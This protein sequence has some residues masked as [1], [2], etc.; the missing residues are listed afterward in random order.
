[1]K[2]IDDIVNTLSPEERELHAELIGECRDRETEVV[3]ISISSQKNIVRIVDL[4][5]K[6][7]LV[8]TAIHDAA[9]KLEDELQKLK[10]NQFAEMLHGIPDDEFHVA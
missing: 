9:S 1:M 8:L 5:S 7:M 4:S 2:I 10:D 3:Q 6:A